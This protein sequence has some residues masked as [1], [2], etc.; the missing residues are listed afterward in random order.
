MPRDAVP[1][2]TPPEYTLWWRLT[3]RCAARVR[4]PGQISWYVMPG[5]ED[6]GQA[7]IQGQYFPLSRRIVLAGHYVRN[8][9]LVRHEML[10]AIV[11][12]TG[13]PAEDFQ[14]RCGGVVACDLTCLSEGG[15]LPRPDTM[16][17]IVRPIDLDVTARV[18]STRP[19]LARDSG[20][21]ALTIAIRNPRPTAVRLRLTPLQPGYFA[22]ATYGYRDGRCE[23]PLIGG[24]SYSYVEDSTIVLGAG[25]TQRKVYDFQVLS[26]CTVVT[27]FFNED[28]LPSIRIEPQP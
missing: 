20:W 11:G 18:D 21:V 16:G 3:E 17:P 13:H 25:E 26:V 22:S 27:P 5:A 8:A 2:A 1:M 14:R 4:D 9:P 6:L 15:A 23:A 28:T 19:S 24:Y 7:N 10:H 12:T